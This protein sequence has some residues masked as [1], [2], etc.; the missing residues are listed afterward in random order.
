MSGTFGRRNLGRREFLRRSARS[1][2][3]IPGAG[4]LLAACSKPGTTPSGTSVGVGGLDLGGPYP[5]ATVDAPVTWERFD[6]NP[7]IAD[8]LQPEEGATLEIFNWSDYVWKKVV[9]DFCAE[10]GCDFRITTFQNM[11]EALAKLRTGEL[12]FDVFFP[13]TDTFGKLVSSKLLQPLNHSYLPNLATEVWPVYADPYYDGEARYSVPYI[14]YT[15]GISYRRNV[16]ADEVIRGLANPYEILWDPTY[17][18]RVGVYDSYR[19][20][21]SEALLKN[22]ITDVNTDRKADI[23]V[24]GADLVRLVDL[25]DVRATTNGAYQLLPENQFDLHTAWSGDAVAGWF[26]V[27][28][29]TAYEDLGYWFP[30]DRRGLVAN[31]TMAVPSNAEHPVL[32]H[33]F[34]NYLLGH[35]AAMKNFSWTGYQPPQNDADPDTLTT[36]DGWWG[37]PYVFP[38]MEAAVVRPEDFEVGYPQWELTPEVDDLWHDAWQNFTVGAG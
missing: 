18:G 19:D 10:Y 12:R 14:V 6:D 8:G 37:Q 9:Q 3:A 23:D 7:M 28:D 25:V 36:T 29:D 16:V 24:A 20:T 4:A 2:L 1:A 30:E 38:W 35:E 33:L 31:D 27:S 5:I 15:T 26:Y 21:M 34:L 13:T 22:G 11:D 17:A 32:A